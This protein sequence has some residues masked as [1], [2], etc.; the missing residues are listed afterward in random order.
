MSTTLKRIILTI[1][2]VISLYHYT[3]W[4]EY[5]TTAKQQKE[6]DQQL[7]LDEVISNVSEQDYKTWNGHVKVSINTANV[8]FHPFSKSVMQ[9]SFRNRAMYFHGDSIIYYLVFAILL[10]LSSLIFAFGTTRTK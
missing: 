8:Q 4:G 2:V 7:L 6:E 1:L 9:R 3:Y 10:I 5:D